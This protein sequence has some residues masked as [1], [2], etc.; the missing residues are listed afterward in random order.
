MGAGGVLILLGVV[1]VLAVIAFVLAG[2]AGWLGA[3]GSD[4]ERQIG[5]DPEQRPRHTRVDL[6]QN[7]QDE[8]HGDPVDRVP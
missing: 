4:P 3:R 1:V 7:T 5:S 2:N 6:D 8:P